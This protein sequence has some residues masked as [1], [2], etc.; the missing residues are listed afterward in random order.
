MPNK[1]LHTEWVGGGGGGKFVSATILGSNIYL[2]YT[3]R[4]IGVPTTMAGLVSCVA[5]TTTFYY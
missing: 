1:L 4:K 2:T 3:Y 5:I